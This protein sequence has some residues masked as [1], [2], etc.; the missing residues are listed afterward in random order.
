MLHYQQ[1]MAKDDL[2]RTLLR[3]GGTASAAE[4]EKLAREL[5]SAK[6]AEMNDAMRRGTIDRPVKVITLTPN[7]PAPAKVKGYITQERYLLNKTPREMRDILGLRPVD[8][9]TGA[10]VL[11][12][13]Q[14]LTM[15]NF[16]NKGYSH[17][18]AGQVWT[19]VSAFPPGEGVGQWKLVYEVNATLIQDVQPGTRYSRGEQHPAT[20]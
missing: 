18:P 16:E 19:P 11:A 12:L 6:L 8:L 15:Q 3:R 1:T 10:R 9:A 20:A 4:L 17:L 7:T 13:T 2:I 5:T 14:P